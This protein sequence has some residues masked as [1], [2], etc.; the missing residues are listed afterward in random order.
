MIVAWTSICFWALSA[1]SL[2]DEELRTH[3]AA[4]CQVDQQGKGHA[5]A[6]E[7]WSQLAQANAGQLN[8]MLGALDTANPLAANWIRTVVDAVAERELARTGRLPLADL[9]GLVLDRSHG[10]KTREL[11]FVWLV[12]ADHAARERLLPGMLNDPCLTLRRMAVE[13]LMNQGR[14]LV[15]QGDKP[16]AVKR[17][18]QALAAARDVDQVRALG[19][20]LNKLGVEV[21][22]PRKLGYVVG[23]QVIGPFDNVG[24]KG[25]EVAYGPEKEV[26]QQAV[27]PGKQGPVRWKPGE[28]TGPF[29]TVD[30]NK[31]LVME[32]GVVGYAL[33]EFHS[34]RE[35][36]VEFRVSSANAV[37]LWLN[38]RLIDEHHVYHS[39][40]QPDQYVSRGTLQ[41][42]RNT[43]LVK[44]CQNEQTQDWAKVWQFQLRVCDLQGAAVN[45]E[46]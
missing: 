35:Q 13:R 7:A 18:E 3:L 20:R 1:G 42:G 23:W 38:G 36:E 11:A 39:G 2:P 19:E 14:D 26:N 25:Y 17:Y 6:A 45:S 46:R 22:L 30:L 16:Q 41:A 5:Q 40:V 21:D 28:G 24:D 12:Q 4:I 43:I 27:Y 8:L 10:P 29:A 9:E 32:K 34:S 37:K 33:N 15:E 31:L 44:L